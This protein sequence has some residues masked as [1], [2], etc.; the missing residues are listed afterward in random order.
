MDLND[1]EYQKVEYRLEFGLA[2]VSSF[3]LAYV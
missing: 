1:A 2:S 3:S